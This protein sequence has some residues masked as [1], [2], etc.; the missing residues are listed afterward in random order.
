MLIDA[1]FLPCLASSVPSTS[2]APNGPATRAR[3]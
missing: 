3:L 2:A 1:G